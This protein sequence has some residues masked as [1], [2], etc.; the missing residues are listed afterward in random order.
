MSNIKFKNCE[1]S[2]SIMDKIQ[3]L[4]NDTIYEI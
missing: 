3:N 4:T 2:M 1:Y